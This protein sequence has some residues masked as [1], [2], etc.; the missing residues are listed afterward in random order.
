MKTLQYYSSTGKLTV[1]PNYDIDDNGAI[2]NINTGQVLTRRKTAGYNRVNVYLEGKQYSVRVARAIA[3]TFIGPPPT[4]HHTVDHDDRNRENDTLENIR[5]ANISEQNKNQSKPSNL[6]SAFI[7]EKD[8]IEHT[9]SEWI[10]KLKNETNHLG[11]MYTAGAIKAYAQRQTNGFRYKT[12]PTL[13][14]EVWK[15]V[16]G[17]KNSQGEWLISNMNR[18]KYKTTYAENVLTTDKLSKNNGYPVICISGKHWYCH[19]LSLMTFRPREYAA[20]IPGDIIL[21][22]HDDRL[23]FNP[24]RLRLG[25]SSENGIDAHDNGKYAGTK[26]E[27]RSVASYIDDILE[28]E[29]VSINAATRYLREIGYSKADKSG[30]QRALRDGVTRYDRTWK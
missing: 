14:G 2:K 13:R 11:R 18:M 30:I 8:G 19:E 26:T 16:R 27:R 21:H 15:A 5:W 1:F 25:S 9:I 7:I 12:F 20:K 22:K 6:Q 29:H 10:E 23:D 28:R 4:L 24:F 17:S 3:S